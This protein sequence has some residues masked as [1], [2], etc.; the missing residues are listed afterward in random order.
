MY[1]KRANYFSRWKLI[2]FFR[3]IINSTCERYSW[4]RLSRIWNINENEV[5]INTGKNCE[6]AVTTC[7]LIDQ[8]NAFA[9]C[10]YAIT[11]NAIIAINDTHSDTLYEA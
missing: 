2:R 10:G 8:C 1:L 5:I 6:N 3:V 11:K 7:V 9:N 4:I